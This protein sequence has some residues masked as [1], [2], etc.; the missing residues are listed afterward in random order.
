MDSMETSAP[1]DTV[2]TIDLDGVRLEIRHLI[3]AP[4]TRN[5]PISGFA[6]AAEPPVL[7]FLHEGL[8]SVAMWR[9]WPQRVC[10]ATGNVGLVYS[11]RGYGESA[12]IP[13]VRAWPDLKKPLEGRLPADY[14][15]REAWQVLPRLLAKLNIK[16]PI[17]VGHSDGA[18]IALLYAARFPAAAC[19]V[20]A[21]HV[22]VESQSITAITAARQAYEN[23]DL[24]ARLA[25]F[26]ADVD[27]AFW[28]WNDVWL[29]AEFQDFDIREHCSRIRC[30]V[31]AIQGIDDPYGSL[32]Q[33]EQIRPQGDRIAIHPLE[34]CGHSP[35]REQ[36]GKTTQLVKDFI[37]S[38]PL[39]GQY[40]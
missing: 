29:S 37:V 23:A 9:A 17:L 18:S 27:S 32:A 38:L 19:I 4:P 40:D 14:L 35:H 8:G 1:T 39:T 16:R 12:L 7:V 33:I 13:N 11:R 24:R 31:L 3:A 28:Q 34:K 36:E 26:H 6:D 22:V 30:P 15:H 21:P 5:N 2:N 10:D 20:M 25:R